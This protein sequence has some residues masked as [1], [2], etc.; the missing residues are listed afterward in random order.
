M[1]VPGANRP[2]P[3][4]SEL[5]SVGF[6]SGRESRGV[7][8]E[9]GFEFGFGV[10]SASGAK[11]SRFAFNIAAS[12]RTVASG[13]VSTG[14]PQLGQ[15]RAVSGALVPHEMQNMGVG[16]YHCRRRPANSRIAPS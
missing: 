13:S 5:V 3:I 1:M 2:P 10:R 16:F 7:R 14:F 11:V 4:G 8:G 15:K 9:V 6:E 12:P